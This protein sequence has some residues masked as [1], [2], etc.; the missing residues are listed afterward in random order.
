M[1]QITLTSSFVQQFHQAALTLFI[2]HQDGRY[3]LVAAGSWAT[4]LPFCLEDIR[5]ACGD[6][7]AAFCG[8]E[9]HLYRIVIENSC[10]RAIPAMPERK[11]DR[12]AICLPA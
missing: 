7:I 4:V 3:G 6:L 2:G 10:I 9:Q 8:G 5:T 11:E 12:S 1:E